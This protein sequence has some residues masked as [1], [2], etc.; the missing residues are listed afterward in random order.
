MTKQGKLINSKIT[1]EQYID[2][3]TYRFVVKILLLLEERARTVYVLVIF[4]TT[5]CR[6][7]T[8]TSEKDLC[9]TRKTSN[10]RRNSAPGTQPN[11]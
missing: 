8:R 5:L 9:I 3:D 7:S 4:L 11:R 2:L 10:F 6:A 1:V